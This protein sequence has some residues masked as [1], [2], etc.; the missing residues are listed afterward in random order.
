MIAIPNSHHNNRASETNR[1]YLVRLI[2][3]LTGYLSSINSLINGD[4]LSG[5]AHTHTCFLARVNAT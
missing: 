2:L 4:V 5:F 3:L 1:I